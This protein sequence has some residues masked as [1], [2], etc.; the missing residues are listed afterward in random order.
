MTRLIVIAVAL[1][2]LAVTP[3]SCRTEGIKVGSKK[4]TEGVILG[5]LIKGLVDDPEAPAT[6]AAVPTRHTWEWVSRSR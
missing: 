1:L 2:A 6:P 4:F 3:L 5:E